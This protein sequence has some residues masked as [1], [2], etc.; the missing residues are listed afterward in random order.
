MV[1]AVLRVCRGRYGGCPPDVTSPVQYK[2]ATD[3]A[4]RPDLEALK[5][6]RNDLGAYVRGYDFLSQIIDYADPA[7]EKRAL[8]YRLLSRVM[9]DQSGAI[10]IDVSSVEMTY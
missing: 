4:N 6:C 3:E 7:R 8:F 5:L 9:V 1:I 2:Q 10:G